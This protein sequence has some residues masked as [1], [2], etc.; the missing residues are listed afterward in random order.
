MRKDA[1]PNLQQALDYFGTLQYYVRQG[2]TNGLSPVPPT[3]RPFPLFLS[4]FDIEGRDS[5][6]QRR[7]HDGIELKLNGTPTAVIITK[8]FEI[9]SRP[10]ARMRG[11][12]DYPHVRVGAQSAA[13]MTRL[14]RS[15]RALPFLK[16]YKFSPESRSK[17]MDGNNSGQFFSNSLG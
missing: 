10:I 16:S 11:I 15:V 6:S 7:L 13:R 4:C 9:P 1:S 3:P 2:L 12:P 5:C 8:E 14:L 17:E